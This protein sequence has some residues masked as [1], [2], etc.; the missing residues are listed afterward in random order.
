MCL[1]ADCIECMIKWIGYMGWFILIIH[2]MIAENS[3]YLCSNTHIYSVLVHIST[4]IHSGF[5]TY[6]SPYVIHATYFSPMYICYTKFESLLDRLCFILSK[7][8]EKMQ[9]TDK[10]NKK[11]NSTP[12]TIWIICAHVWNSLLNCN[13]D[14]AWWNDVNVS[15]NNCYR[16][17]GCCSIH[18]WCA[19]VEWY[20]HLPLVSILIPFA[21]KTHRWLQK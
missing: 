20:T 14:A 13:V 8:M 21:Q 12:D 2:N 18:I 5:H 9:I 19:S 3:K 15:A 6:I 17:I 10:K 1:L 4:R 16:I 7:N 11:T